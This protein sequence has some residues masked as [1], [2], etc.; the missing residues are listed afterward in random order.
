MWHYFK[1]FWSTPSDN[2]AYYKDLR[3]LETEQ[4]KKQ[5]TVKNKIDTLMISLANDKLMLSNV[6]KEIKESNKKLNDLFKQKHEIDMLNKQT[7]GLQKQDE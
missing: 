2:P 4:L 5:D 1:S 7:T 3:K 6:E